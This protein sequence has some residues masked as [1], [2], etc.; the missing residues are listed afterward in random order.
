MYRCTLQMPTFVSLNVW[1]YLARQCSIAL[2]VVFLL[3][4]AAA[5]ITLYS[6]YICISICLNV[7]VYSSYIKQLF[8]SMNRCT[9]YMLH[10]SKPQCIADSTNVKNIAVLHK[11]VQYI[12]VLSTCDSSLFLNVPLYLS[13]AY[14]FTQEFYPVYLFSSLTLGT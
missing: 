7:S 1:L 13:S 10:K 11:W 4:I 12:A 6:S 9:H 2:N 14:V 3:F 8:P 5:E